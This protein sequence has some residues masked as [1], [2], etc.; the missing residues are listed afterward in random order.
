MR[1]RILE[2]VRRMIVRDGL[3]AIGVN[4]LAREAACDKV[5]IY[6]YFGDLEGVYAAYA[7][8]SDFWWDVDELT[9]GIDPSRASAGE[10]MKT[11][12]RR[13][14]QA[15]R[16]RPVT[17]AVLAAE[18]VDRTRLVVALEAVRERRALELSAWI[19]QHYRLPPSADVEAVGMLLGVAIN[20][21]AVRARTIRVMGGVKI[22]TDGDWERIFAAIDSL[23]DGVMRVE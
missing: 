11:I 14:A 4:A 16:A 20:Y 17:L 12:L 10:A 13:H 5:L 9:R 21:L 1:A 6:R 7:A 2:A 3:A 23:I 22:K 18:L 15:L 8:Q 19:G